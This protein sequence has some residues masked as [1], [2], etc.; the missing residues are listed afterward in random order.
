M[1]GPILEGKHIRLEPPRSDYAQDYIRWAADPRATL[2]M[3]SRNPV[4]LQMQQ[5]WFE[6]MAASEHDMVWSIVLRENGTLIGDTG[7]HRIDW[8]H[9]QAYSRL[10]IG[11]AA[12]WGRGYGSEVVALRT[13]YAFLEL[14]LEKIMSTVHSG[15]E[16]SRRALERAG[17]RQCGLLRHNRF[18]NGTWHDE[19]MG[20]VLRDEWM[21]QYLASTAQII[22]TNGEAVHH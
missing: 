22:A 9:R 18:Y 8:R 7:L 12:M 17:Y 10:M 3:D 20:E 14:G 21:V 13:A 2:F 1:Y 19:W 6:E 4:S 15:N 16:R 11:E 5:R